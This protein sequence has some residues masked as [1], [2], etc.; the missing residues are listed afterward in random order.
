MNE[1]AEGSPVQPL[2]AVTDVICGS[3]DN[4]RLSNRDLHQNHVIYNNYL[5][6]Q[7]NVICAPRGGGIRFSPHCYTGMDQLDS[8]LAMTNTD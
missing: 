7:N 8:A 5:L 6:M 4:G 3:A 1:G 2:S